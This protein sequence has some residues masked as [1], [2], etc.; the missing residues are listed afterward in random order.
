MLKKLAG[1]GNLL[2]PGQFF[3]LFFPPMAYFNKTEILRKLA[4]LGETLASLLQPGL[5]F[6]LMAF[7]NSDIYRLHFLNINLF[8]IYT[9][10]VIFHFS[11]TFTTLISRPIYSVKNLYRPI[12]YGHSRAGTGFTAVFTEESLS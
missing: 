9:Y 6:P 1:L 12:Y 4:G 5:F 3:L 2:Q 7:F 10:G 11:S 8:K